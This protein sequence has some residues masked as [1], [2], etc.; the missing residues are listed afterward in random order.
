M[1]TWV[2]E[3]QPRLIV[4]AGAG[5]IDALVQPVKELLGNR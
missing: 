3:N 4:M 5:D 2:A 1:K